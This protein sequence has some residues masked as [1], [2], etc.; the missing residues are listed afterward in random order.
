[1]SVNQNERSRS[2]S[3][4]K[5]PSSSK[6]P[7]TS[8][9][10]AAAEKKASKRYKPETTDSKSTKRGSFSSWVSTAIEASDSV[11]VSRGGFLVVVAILVI[12]GLVMLYSASSI[13]SYNQTGDYTA[14]FFKQTIFVAIGAILAIAIALIPYQ[15]YSF[16]LCVAALIIFIPLLIYVLV[17][18]DAAL[19]ARRWID[20]GFTTL[21]PS[22]FAKIALML[23]LAHLVNRCR[24]EGYSKPLIYTMVVACIIPIGLI[25]VEPDLG[26]TII[27]VIGILAVLWFGGVPKRIVGVLGL[28]LVVLA[29][30]AVMGTGFRQTRITSWLSPESDPLNSGYQLLSSYYAF[31][32]G[33]IFGVG[34]G[35]SKQKF[36]W[37]PQ[38]ENDFIFAIVGEELGL[39]GALVVILLFMALVFLALRV[40]SNAPDALGA[41]IAGSSGVIIAGQ[42]FLNM[43]CVVGALPTTG[44]PLP[45]FSAGGS[46]VISTMILVG[47]ILSVSLQSSEATVYDFRREQFTVVNGGN[48]RGAT[49]GRSSILSRLPNPAAFVAGIVQTPVAETPR[50]SA[51]SDKIVPISRGRAEQTTRGAKRVPGGQS[52]RGRQAPEQRHVSTQRHVAQ[53][54]QAP[55]LKQAVGSNR[56]LDRGQSAKR[57]QPSGQSQPTRTNQPVRQKETARQPQIIK[58][59]FQRRRTP[60]QTAPS[61]RRAEAPLSMSSLRINHV[62]KTGSGRN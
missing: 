20:L 37:L 51:S 3:R 49:E 50:R 30:V 4:E 56:T 61:R 31:G 44:K 2:S 60:V 13:Y 5:K 36:N 17:V 8:K 16:K 10:T 45:F 46:S 35:L 33:G 11:L 21:Q 43:L 57:R 32:G 55:Q 53:L 40:A 52:A 27:A 26:T 22:E 47:L 25:V 59:N 19:G 41:M 1:M 62:K 12:F 7:M 23:V 38:S 54:K 48:K 34:L 24:E 29:V 15:K 28:S 39:L 18:G 58:G 6:N 9:R 42:A 14:V